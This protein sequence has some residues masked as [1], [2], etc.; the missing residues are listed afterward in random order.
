MINLSQEEILA[1][2]FTHLKD[3]Y[4]KFIVVNKENPYWFDLFMERLNKAEVIDF[5]VVEGNNTYYTRCISIPVRP[6]IISNMDI[7]DDSNPDSDGDNDDICEPGETIEIFPYVDNV[8]LLQAELVAGTVVS[9]SPN[10]NV[11]DNQPGISG[12]VSSSSFW[13]VALLI[14]MKFPL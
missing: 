2:D 9:P 8:S 14:P 7:D 12:I 11:W 10:I 1:M 5:K 6:L 3:M 13:N 4:V